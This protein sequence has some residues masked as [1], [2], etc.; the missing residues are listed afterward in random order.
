[1]SN[2]ALHEPMSPN[3]ITR[4]QWV[5]HF[6]RFRVIDTY[7]T[8]PLLLTGAKEEAVC[9]DFVECR[10]Y[11]SEWMDALLNRGKCQGPISLMFSFSP[12]WFKFLGNFIFHWPKFYLMNWSLFAHDATAV[13]S[14]PEIEWHWNKISIAFGLLWKRRQWNCPQFM[15][16]ICLNRPAR[17][18]PNGI[19]SAVDCNDECMFSHN[20][21]IWGWL[22][23]W[24]VVYET[25]F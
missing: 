25:T 5:E 24:S 6:R 15:I 14:K 21:E 13:L 1:M 9:T 23:F 10:I 7:F 12:S 3:G 4:P 22:N 8:L 19:H 16:H 11:S 17:M 18:N 20:S 2:T